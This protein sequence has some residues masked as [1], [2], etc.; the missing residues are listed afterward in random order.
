MCYTSQLAVA[1][2]TF[3]PMLLNRLFQSLSAG[4]I[5]ECGAEAPSTAP[6]T[7]QMGFVLS[8]HNSK[9]C[10]TCSGS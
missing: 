10:R 2:S 5:W 4:R 1:E 7:L 6:G 8:L 3:K 9:A